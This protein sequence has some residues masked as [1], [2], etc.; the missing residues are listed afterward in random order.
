[1]K[2][3]E[4]SFKKQLTKGERGDNI[5]KLSRGNNWGSAKNVKKKLKKVCKKAWQE[6][7]WCDILFELSSRRD[8][9]EDSDWTLKIKQRDKKR[10]PRFDS[11]LTINEEFKKYFSN[12]NTEAKIAKYKVS[13]QWRNERQS[14]ENDLN[15]SGCFNTI[16]REFDPGSGRTLAACLTHASRTKHLSESLRGEAFMT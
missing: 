16:F 2:N 5:N 7:I 6:D 4:K 8:S 9:L 11:E 12:S 15:S 14:S 1:M 10:N 13:Q 3:V